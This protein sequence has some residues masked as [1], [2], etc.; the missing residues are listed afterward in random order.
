MYVCVTVWV[1][2]SLS[3]ASTFSPHRPYTLPPPS[4][5]LL[6]P[7][8]GTLSSSASPQTLPYN[9]TTAPKKRGRKCGAVGAH[10]E[11]GRVVRVRVIWVIMGVAS[12]AVVW[13]IGIEGREVEER[14][15]MR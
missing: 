7:Q 4:F 14:F 8:A 3:L 1:C 11:V 13:G 12:V 10:L 6:P 9:F 2:A 15:N 5:P